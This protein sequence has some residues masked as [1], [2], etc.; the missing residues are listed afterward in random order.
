MKRPTS[1]HVRS[2]SVFS[3]Y[4]AAFSSASIAHSIVTA[5]AGMVVGIVA[6]AISVAIS[7]ARIVTVGAIVSSIVSALHVTATKGCAD[8]RTNEKCPQKIST[9]MKMMA[10][11]MMMSEKHFLNPLFR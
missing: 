7:A 1:I 11:M 8:Q 4:G 6:I 10:A 2:M 9:S 5:V 3:L